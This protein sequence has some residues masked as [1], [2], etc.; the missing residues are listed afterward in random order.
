MTKT[1][2]KVGIK[3]TQPALVSLM[4]TLHTACLTYSADDLLLKWH[5]YI[6]PLTIISFILQVFFN[7]DLLCCWVLCI[8]VC[9]FIIYWQSFWKEKKEIFVI[10][11][12]FVFIYIF[13]VI[14]HFLLTKICLKLTSVC[15]RHVLTCSVSVTKHCAK[16]RKNKNESIFS[17]F[18]TIKLITY[19]FMLL[20]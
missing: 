1:L 4:G 12:T 13:H 17:V 8:L 3:D 6:L 7:L 18:R 2:F 14:H 19:I 20:F 10:L 15:A 9:N 16:H 11:I 5:C